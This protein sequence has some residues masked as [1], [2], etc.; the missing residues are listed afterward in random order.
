ML[1]LSG[2]CKLGFSGHVTQLFL[3]P[4]YIFLATLGLIGFRKFGF[5]GQVTN[6][7]LDPMRMIL[8]DAQALWDCV[9]GFS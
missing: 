9:L 7:F 2:L 3:S 6:I 4:V 5:S 8:S 1:V